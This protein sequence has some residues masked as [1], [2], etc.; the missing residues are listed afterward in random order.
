MSYPKFGSGMSRFVDSFL[1]HFPCDG[2]LCRLF[3]SCWIRRYCSRVRVWVASLEEYG[4]ECVMFCCQC[5]TSN[6]SQGIIVWGD[7]VGS[8]LVVT[9]AG[10]GFVMG[11]GEVV[12]WVG[13]CWTTIGTMLAAASANAFN[14]V[15]LCST[16]V[17]TFGFTYFSAVSKSCK[18]VSSSD[19][20]ILLLWFWSPCIKK[21]HILCCGLHVVLYILQPST[22]CLDLSQCPNLSILSHNSFPEG[23]LI[24]KLASHVY[25][26]WTSIFGSSHVYTS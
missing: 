23:A 1:Q 11:S 12:D 15:P 19:P 10:V 26:V 8:L 21:C 13:L 24:W 18:S 6:S 17:P 3:S 2:T 16:F 14:Q 5:N 9:T 25:Q 7:W 20:Y 22:A 4:K